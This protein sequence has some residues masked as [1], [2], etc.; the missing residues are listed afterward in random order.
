[1]GRK[2]PLQV[3]RIDSFN[4]QRAVRVA[5]V[6][7]SSPYDDFDGED[8][9][10]L[11]IFSLRGSQRKMVEIAAEVSNFFSFVFSL[12]NIPTAKFP[13]SVHIDEDNHTIALSRNGK[14]TDDDYQK[15]CILMEAVSSVNDWTFRY[16]EGSATDTG[17][18]FTKSL[19]S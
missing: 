3:L 4:L 5:E 16:N 19:Q 6:F 13:Q 2:I 12:A 18:L 10:T 8:T 7:F 17:P 1:M 14:W 15:L 11:I 9:P